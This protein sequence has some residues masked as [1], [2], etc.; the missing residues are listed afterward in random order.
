MA[1]SSVQSPKSPLAF[2]THTSLRLGVWRGSAPS[3]LVSLLARLWRPVL[4]FWITLALSWVTASFLTL[5]LTAGQQ[6]MPDLSVVR[7]ALDQPWA[8]VAALGL[9]ALLTPCVYLAHRARLPRSPFLL[10]RVSALAGHADQCIPRYL[11][12]FYLYRVADTETRELLRA[13]AR[14]V[15]DEE[16]LGICIFGPPML[17]KTR[18]AWEA[19]QVELH[20]WTLA[21]WPSEGRAPFDFAALRGR[22][23]VL[24]LDDLEQYAHLTLAPTLNDLPRR[25]AEVGA[26]LVVVATCRDGAALRRALEHLSPLL[27][28][29]API[30]PAAISENEVAWHAAALKYQGV[31]LHSDQFDGTPG[32]IVL[33]TTRMV[34]ERYPALPKRAQRALRAMKLLRSAGISSYPE[35]RVRATAQDVFRLEPRQWRRAR[36]TLARA[37][38]IRLEPLPSGKGC[39]L[40]PVADVYLEEAVPDYM[41][42]GIDISAGWRELEKSLTGRADADALCQLGLAFLERRVGSASVNKQHAEACLRAAL[43]VYQRQ[44]AHAAWAIAQGHLGLTHWNQAQVAQP[45]ERGVLLSQ[46]VAAYRAALRVG[47]WERIPLHWAQMQQSLG[48]ALSRQA[49]L[50]EGAER[51]ALQA[52][53]LEAARDALALYERAQALDDLARAQEGLGVALSDQARLVE[54]EEQANL[55]SQAATAYRAA[56]E[57]YAQE[58]VLLNWARAQNNLGIALMQQAEASE[59]E[60]RAALL[61]EAQAAH[62]AALKVYSREET[63]EGWARTQSNLGNVARHQA[64]LAG[65]AERVDLL[66][67]AVAAYRAALKVYSREDAPEEWAMT[68]NNLGNAL[69]DQAQVEAGEKRLTLLSQAATA[70]QAALTIYTREYV[71]VE[72]AGTNLNLAQVYLTRALVLKG[73]HKVKRQTLGKAQEAIEQ[74]LTIFS[75]DTAPAY[76][77]LALRVYD[78]I[79]ERLG[80]EPLPVASQTPSEADTKPALAGD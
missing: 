1:Y 13:A 20:D 76:H 39:A 56:L 44:G 5:L 47:Q 78:E 53:A 61:N 8:V 34:L 29:L 35:A 4:W 19:M 21:R 57:V 79:D 14:R 50:A 18:M 73:T 42:P 60:A 62:Q 59:C 26:Q 74:A 45:S 24:W 68:Q 64:E 23:V 32:S 10:K 52:Q 3:S 70:H 17:G 40:R 77:A 58:P 46:A 31:R 51:E 67:L 28:L 43:A 63:P 36:N 9:V 41:P 6:N 30:Y 7:L 11:A 25:F 37:G 15:D 12:N 65:P 71:P 69:S 16:P 27:A 55:L 2:A 54:G 33:E 22:R 48:A 75:P 66:A 38:F 49:T 72:W 80:S